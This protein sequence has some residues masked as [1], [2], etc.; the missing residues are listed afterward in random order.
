MNGSRRY[1]MSN[2]EFGGTAT[3]DSQNDSYR[4]RGDLKNLNLAAIR[5]RASEVCPTTAC[6]PGPSTSR[7]T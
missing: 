1:P 3:L 2:C 4:V 5:A 7:E 6:Y